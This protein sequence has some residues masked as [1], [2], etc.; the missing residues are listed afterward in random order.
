VIIDV[1]DK[2]KVIDDVVW[3]YR[4]DVHDDLVFSTGKN[5]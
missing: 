3:S 1:E 4:A 5:V 2:D